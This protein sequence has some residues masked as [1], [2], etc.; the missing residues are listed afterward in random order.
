MHDKT[1]SPKKRR[2]RDALIITLI[3]IVL[4]IPAAEIALRITCDYCT[5]TETSGD[6][7]VSPWEIREDSW[8]HTGEPNSV[9]QIQLPEFNLEIRT[10]SLGLA[11]QQGHRQ[12]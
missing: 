2:I 10:N 7:F 6:G 5:W 9:T 3:T 1:P 12:Y 11:A 8:Y 4:L